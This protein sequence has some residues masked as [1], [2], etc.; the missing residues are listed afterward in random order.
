MIRAIYSQPLLPGTEKSAAA[1]VCKILFLFLA[2][3]SALP[4]EKASLLF[5]YVDVV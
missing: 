1:H 5:L 3:L 4:T 2:K